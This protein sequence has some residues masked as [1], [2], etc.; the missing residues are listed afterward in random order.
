MKNRR[1]PSVRQHQLQPQDL[2]T[3]RGGSNGVIHSD[4]IVGGGKAI[5]GGGVARDNGVIQMHDEGVIQIQR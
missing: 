5:V 1:K 4:A 2:A 3:V